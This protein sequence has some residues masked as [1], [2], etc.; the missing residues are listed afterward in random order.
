MS[1]HTFDCYKWED[2]KDTRRAQPR[3]LLFNILP[4]CRV[5]WLMPLIL[6]I[7]E[8]ETGRVAVKANPGKKFSRSHFKQ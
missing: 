4:C 2:A 6:A 8:V 5:W 7:Q 3:R 1:G